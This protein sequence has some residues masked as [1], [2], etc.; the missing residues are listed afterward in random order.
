MH[1]LAFVGVRL[2]EV[3]VKKLHGLDTGYGAVTVGPHSNYGKIRCL[4][5]H[6]YSMWFIHAQQSPSICLFIHH[7]SQTL[8]FHKFSFSDGDKAESHYSLTILKCQ[9][10]LF[11]F[12]SNRERK[13]LILRHLLVVLLA[14]RYAGLSVFFQYRLIAVQDHIILFVYCSVDQ[15]SNTFCLHDSLQRI[16]SN[17]NP[18][19]QLSGRYIFSNR[20]ADGLDT[21]SHR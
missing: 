21:H 2:R 16:C 19:L 6:H 12:P 8:I 10:I 3:T 14:N 18:Q 5:L 1:E 4:A 11:W 17:Y 15:Q 20:L 13:A 7:W 9:P